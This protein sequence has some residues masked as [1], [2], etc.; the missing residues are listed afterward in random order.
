MVTGLG[1]LVPRGPLLLR[2]AMGPSHRAR[3]AGMPWAG[4]AFPR[5]PCITVRLPV[6]RLALLQSSGA[7]PV[8]GSHRC[9]SFSPLRV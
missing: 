7:H 6:P 8:A 2:A 3:L 4:P 5:F 9:S 1:L